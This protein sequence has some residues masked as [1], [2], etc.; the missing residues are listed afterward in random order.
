MIHSPFL[1]C[2]LKASISFNVCGN[3]QSRAATFNI[4]MRR[5][6]IDRVNQPIAALTHTCLIN[7]LPILARE[8][9]VAAC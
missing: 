2:D 9:R 5:H 4:L 3:T 1:D 6:G 8:R 7:S